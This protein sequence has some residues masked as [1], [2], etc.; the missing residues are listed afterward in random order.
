MPHP[1]LYG[2]NQLLVPPRVGWGV[3]EAQLE[4]MEKTPEVGPR[5]R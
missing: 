5:E 4:K 3:L 1:T 2:P